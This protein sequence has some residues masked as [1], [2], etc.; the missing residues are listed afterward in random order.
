MAPHTG[1]SALAEF[2]QHIEPSGE[3][4]YVP[5]LGMAGC[6]GQVMDGFGSEQIPAVRPSESHRHCKHAVALSK[7]AYRKSPLVTC[8]NCTS[9]GDWH[10]WK[11]LPWLNSP[12]CCAVAM[13]SKLPTYT[14]HRRPCV[15]FMLRVSS[16]QWGFAAE[17]VTQ[18]AMRR[19][20]TQYPTM[21]I[22]CCLCMRRSAF[23]ASD[24]KK[25]PR[26]VEQG[27]WP[28]TA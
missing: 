3:H 25:R 14:V 19:T 10:S 23:A 20:S 5:A 8:S 2:V 22:R 1:Q 13:A 12:C 4:W 7:L 16:P 6:A 18:A 24:G 21:M 11:L 9:A 27:S 15:G 28:T 17:E 26:E